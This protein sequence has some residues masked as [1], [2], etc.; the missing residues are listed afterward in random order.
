VASVG[1]GTDFAREGRIAGQQEE[2]L[3]DWGIIMIIYYKNGIFF[4]LS[5]CALST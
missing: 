2:L 5:T 1:D 4:E 3:D